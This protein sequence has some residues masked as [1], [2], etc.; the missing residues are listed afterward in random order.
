MELASWKEGLVFLLYQP[1]Y[2]KTH[3]RTP[4]CYTNLC[5]AAECYLLLA[6]I[7]Q[8]AALFVFTAWSDAAT[9]VSATK[10]CGN[11]DCVSCL[12]LP[13]ITKSNVMLR[14]AA[15]DGESQG[16]IPDYP[17]TVSISTCRQWGTQSEFHL[18][19]FRAIASNG[20]SQGWLTYQCQAI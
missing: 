8:H 20:Y 13:V 12:F 17:P 1:S 19:L 9:V 14:C 4:I 10:L 18:L 3:T 15:S 11:T 2:V 5:I 16:A 6:F 7:S